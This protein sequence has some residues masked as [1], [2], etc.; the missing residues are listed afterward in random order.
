VVLHS[1]AFQYFPAGTQERIAR[2]VARVGASARPDAPVAWLRYELEDLQG[3]PTLRLR[4]W[5]GG[6]DRLLAHA[7]PHGR[8]IKWVA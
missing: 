4:M 8:W 7:D 6:K 3:I 5:P 1:I 2:H